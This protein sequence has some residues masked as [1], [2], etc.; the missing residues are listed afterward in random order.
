MYGLMGL[1]T[2]Q[3]LLSLDISRSV[4]LP[5]QYTVNIY[6]KKFRMQ[7]IMY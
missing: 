1:I 7:N 6:S 3:A 2:Q 4:W 5:V